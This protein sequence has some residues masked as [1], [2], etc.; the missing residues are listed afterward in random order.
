M[1]DSV[2]TITL[3]YP[4]GNLVALSFGSG[5]AFCIFAVVV[6][7]CRYRSGEGAFSKCMNLDLGMYA[8]I[9]ASELKMYYGHC[10]IHC[11]SYT[12]AVLKATR[13]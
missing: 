9:Y 6:E 8:A 11:K 1:Q 3:F 12:V 7:T 10:S 2:L 13:R 5:N 4:L